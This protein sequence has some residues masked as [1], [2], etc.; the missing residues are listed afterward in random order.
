MIVMSEKIYA[1]D[2]QYSLIELSENDKYNYIRLFKGTIELY[3][4]K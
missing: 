1:T 3:C 4:K 2:G